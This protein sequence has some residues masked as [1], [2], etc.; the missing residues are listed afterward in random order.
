M[1]TI[2]VY[3]K[4]HL[5]YINPITLKTNTNMKISELFSNLVKNHSIFKDYN[6]DIIY[7]G[8]KI[9]TTSAKPLKEYN[10]KYNSQLKL[11]V[12]HKKCDFEFRNDKINEVL[13]DICTFGN[14]MKTKILEESEKNPDKFIKID[15]AIKME[16]EDPGLFS[17]A[18]I[19][20]TLK[21][22]GINVLIEKENNINE[23]EKSLELLCN[24]MIYKKK[25]DFVFDFGDKTNSDILNNKEEYEKFKNKLKKKLSK[26][27]DIPEDEIIITNPQKGSVRVQLIFQSNEF[28]NL[29]INEFKEK[30]IKDPNYSELKYLKEIHNDVIVSTCALTIGQLDSE[31]NRYDGWPINEYRGGKPYYSPQGWIGIGLK[32][33]DKYL[34]NIWIGMKNI[35]GEWCVAYHGVGRNQI[36]EQVKKS[37]RLIYVGGFKPGDNQVYEDD[38]DIYHEGQKVGKGVYI[39]PY[40][41][42]AEE[43][44]GICRING[45]D[46]KTVMMVRVK[47]EVIRCPKKKPEYWV[48]NGTTDEVRPYRILYKEVQ[49]N[50]NYN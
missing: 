2:Y 14:E 48:A 13:E 24:G 43:Y 39:T 36:P 44:A 29:K 23:C 8:K 16:K 12:T 33:M 50:K 34:D 18:L 35:S 25:Y 49:N 21:D 22:C 28:N 10:I 11:K 26:M 4:H 32:V 17:L 45:R 20:K 31:G 37:T 40:I 41:E 15:E 27:Y 5:K 9:P 19:S 6:F 7:N 42:E 1:S 3:I 38:E 46:Y 30:F 47:P